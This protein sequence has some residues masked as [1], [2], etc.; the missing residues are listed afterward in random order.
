[1]CLQF[2]NSDNVGLAQYKLVHQ[3]KEGSIPKVT[4]ALGTTQAL[5]LGEFL[6]TDSSTPSNFTVFA[7]HKKEPNSANQQ[8]D[9]LICHLTQEQDQKKSLDEIKASLK[10]AVHVPS[11]VVSLGTQLQLFA[12]ASC[13]LFGN[14]SICINC[15]KH[16]LLLLDKTKRALTINTLLQD[17]FLQLIGEFKGSFQCLSK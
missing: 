17:P 16:L 6:H 10:Q 14:K 9:F 15:L 12:A 2:I 7:F 5:F 3:F 1:M 8:T 13:I 4:F 11:N